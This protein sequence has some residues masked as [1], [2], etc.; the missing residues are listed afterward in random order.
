MMEDR[1]KI[2]HEPYR[3]MRYDKK[4]FETFKMINNY[5]LIKIQN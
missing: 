2:D 3:A 1:A 5:F 4:D